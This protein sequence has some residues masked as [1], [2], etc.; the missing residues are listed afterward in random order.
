MNPVLALGLQSL[1]LDAARIERI[2]MN[3]A[4]AST[5][6]YAASWIESMQQ[7]AAPAAPGSAPGLG[8][9]AASPAAGALFSFHDTRPGSLKA[10]GRALDLA[11]AGEGFFELRTDAGTAYTRRGDLSLDARGLLVDAAGH[12]VL[13]DGGE[14]RLDAPPVIDALGRVFVRDAD[15]QLP[16]APVDRLRIVFL[17]PQASREPLGQGAFRSAALPVELKDGARRVQQGFLENAQVDPLREMSRL[18]QAMRHA[19]GLQRVTQISDD[20]LGQALRT[21]GSNS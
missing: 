1:Q 2:A 5:P 10:T 21:L 15:G 20:L 16:A 4:N 18:M 6:G 13:G 17:D 3:I 9:E 11:I 19:E 12:P 8:P 14:I 7:A